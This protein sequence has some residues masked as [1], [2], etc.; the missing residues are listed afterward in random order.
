MKLTPPNKKTLPWVLVAVFSVGLV[1]IFATKPTAKRRPPVQAPKIE[2]HTLT[3]AAQTFPITIQ[4]YGRVKA[5]NHTPLTSRVAGNVIFVAE[6]AR[7][8][9]VFKQGERL[10]GI[11]KADYQIELDIARAQVAEA[12]SRY[13]NEVALAKEA[14]HD[15]KR[16]GRSGEPPALAVREPQLKAAKA[17]LISAE[18]AEKRAELNLSRTHIIAPYDG[19]VSDLHVDL[20]Q[21]ISPNTPLATI[22]STAAAELTLPIKQN[23]LRFLSDGNINADSQPKVTIQSTRENSS[24]WQGALTRITKTVDE[25]SNQ[26]LAIA[27]IPAPF[28]ASVDGASPLRVG[29]YVTAQISGTA[30]ENAIVIPVHTIYQGRYVYVLEN[31]KAVYRRSITVAWSNAESALVSEGLNPGDVLILT[32]L[33]QVPSGTPVRVAEPKVSDKQKKDMNKKET[34]AP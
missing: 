27:R 25:Q 29:E 15:W 11:E 1:L 18:A 22:F 34:P 2:V 13:A 4:S 33:G 7:L 8:G 12:Q 16:S 5:L 30:V 26:L 24:S 14:Q 9:G 20:G 19:S 21:Y 31:D 23:E 6:N 3:I 28:H 17:A 32:A 10:I